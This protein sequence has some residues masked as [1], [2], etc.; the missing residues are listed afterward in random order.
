MNNTPTNPH[1]G[2][3]IINQTAI[4]ATLACTLSATIT[5]AEPGEDGSGFEIAWY[6][7]DA[8]GGTSIGGGFELTGT[9]GQPDAGTATA[10]QFELT[11]GFWVGGGPTAPPCPGDLNGDAVV[12]ID[13]LAILLNGFG[14]STA[15]D[16]NGDGVTDT[17]DLA[18]LLNAFGQTCR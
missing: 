3:R 4:L 6:T 8:G 12:D 1:A 14:S 13:D 9:I 15:G 11:G 10:A 17:N 5:S 18:I 7:I 16:L 2:H